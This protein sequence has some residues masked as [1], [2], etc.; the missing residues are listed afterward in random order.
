M[1]HGTKP[2]THEPLPLDPEHDIDAKSATW[3]VVGG[4][5]VLFLSLWVMVPIFMRVQEAERERK[6]DS[7]PNTERNDVHDAEMEFLQGANPTKKSIDAVLKR[8]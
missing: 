2:S 3:W 1:G 6:V 8:N 7:A 5:I 4:S